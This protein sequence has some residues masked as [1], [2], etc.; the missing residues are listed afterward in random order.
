MRFREKKQIDYG[1][2]G[3]EETKDKPPQ[4]VG[5]RDRITHFTWWV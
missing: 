2:E 1:A 5:L 3:Q 4:F